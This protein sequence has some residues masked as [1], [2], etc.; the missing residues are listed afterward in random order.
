MS[1][2][3][4]KPVYGNQ[5]NSRSNSANANWKLADEGSHIYRILP[6]YGSLAASGRWSQYE[7]LHWGFQ[8]STG[9][10]RAFRCIQ[11]KNRKT[12]MIEVECPM[13][14]KIEEQKNVLADRMKILKEQGKTKDQ[15]KAALEPLND[16]LQ[17]FNIQKG[18]FLN[19]LREDRQIGR[20]FIKIR[21]KQALDTA[22]K[23]LVEKEHLDPIA[24]EQGVWLDFQRTGMGRDNTVYN[25]VPAM[26]DIEVNGRRLK[27][28]KEAPLSDELLER[29]K[30]EAW[31]LGTFNKDLTFNEIQMLVSSDGDPSI[32]DSVFGA[33]VSSPTKAEPEY[34][35]YDEEDVDPTPA[36]V[37]VAPKATR[38]EPG[39]S[40]SK[41]VRTSAEEFMASLAKDDL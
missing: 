2:E 39:K 3:I 13:C 18:H 32:A 6:P 33:P 30:K 28:I 21:C 38:A 31:D 26:E 27:S 15:V 4:G 14:T 35:E 23:D 1:Q 24:S 40:T 11:R 10:K 16:W 34:D 41:A 17:K 37:P 19:V 12:G 20:L 8:L 22:L 9:K 7:A 29:M 25:V 5:T 36:P